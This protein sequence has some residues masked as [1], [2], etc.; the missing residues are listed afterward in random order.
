MTHEKDGPECERAR[1]C[2]DPSVHS[3]PETRAAARTIRR[4]SSWKQASQQGAANL[5]RAIFG[6]TPA[7]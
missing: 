2:A 3:V 1:N 5:M 6:G 7:A 4:D